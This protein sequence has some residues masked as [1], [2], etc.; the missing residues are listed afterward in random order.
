MKFKVDDPV[1]VEPRPGDVGWIVRIFPY[2]GFAYIR[3]SR[4]PLALARIPI[5]EL[6]HPI[7]LG[8]IIPM[9]QAELFNQLELA[10]NAKAMCTEPLNPEL[11]HWRRVAPLVGEELRAARR[12]QTL[13]P[14]PMST[15][16][17]L[18]DWKSYDRYWR[19]VRD[20]LV[21]H[22]PNIVAHDISEEVRKRLEEAE[23][24]NKE[25]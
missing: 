21:K 24:G 1:W 11:P 6:R 7:R 14:A 16:E 2:S 20:E 9:D 12:A 23:D 15:N 13:G 17:E 4:C 5:D 10:R 22:K 18:L 8:N 19:A 25:D 3:F